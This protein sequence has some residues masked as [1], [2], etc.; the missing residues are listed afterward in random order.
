MPA[1][2]VIIPVYNVEEYLNRCVNSILAQTFTD[3]ELILVDD[4]SADCSL[5]ICE[6]YAE[7]DNR[8]KVLHQENH[9]ASVA[10]NFGVKHASGKY[11]IF[12]DSDDWVAPEY[13]ERLYKACIES[14]ADISVIHFEGGATEENAVPV[15]SDEVLVQ[16]NREAIN[17]YG[18]ICGPNFRSPVAKMVKR[19]IV[20]KYPFPEDRIWSEDT[21]CVYKWYWEANK[22]V[23]IFGTMYFYFSPPNSV[24]NSVFDERYLGELETYDEMLLFYEKNAF[25]ELEKVFFERYLDTACAYYNKAKETGNTHLANEFMGRIRSIMKRYKKKYQINMK[26]KT[27]L[28]DFVYPRRTHLYRIFKRIIN[29]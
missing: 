16:N 19:E 14:Q 10:R 7:K 4:G 3:F 8:I 13:L 18:K 12:V 29:Q 25:E 1:I 2:S 28:Y 5:I 24:S 17:C 27:D 26:R 20:A 23:E 6:E 11:I 21:A 9:G 15:Y 22:V